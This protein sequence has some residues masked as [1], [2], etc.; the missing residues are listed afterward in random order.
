MEAK[1]VIRMYSGSDAN[2]TE[3]ARAIYD[4]FATDLTTFKL[5]DST[6]NDAFQTQFL[7]EVEAAEQVVDDA[8]VIDQ[9]VDLSSKADDHLEKAREKYDDVKYFVQKAFPNSLGIQGEFGLN[10]YMRVRRNRTEMASFLHEMNLTCNKYSAEL[11]AAGFNQAAIDEIL[12]I[13]TNLLDKNASQELLKRQR[14]KL[15]EDRIIILNTCYNTMTL[16]NAA[17]QR[18]FRTDYAKQKQYV[19]DP[20][21][22][23]DD[24]FVY[25]GNV[26]AATTLTLATVVYSDTTTVSFRNTGTASLTFALSTTNALEGNV[27]QLDGGAEITKAMIELLPNG[28][29]LIVRNNDNTQGGSYEVT[30]SE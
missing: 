29:K 10:D 24:T 12:T 6:L 20:S 21:S 2:M 19:F 5:F 13:R 1:E 7:S 28:T 30:V 25:A 17:A 14:P 8:V 23:V 4:L 22:Q 26:S 9:I 16:I 18:V 27:V 3:T 15:T 11:L